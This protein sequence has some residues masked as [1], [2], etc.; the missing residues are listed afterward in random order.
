MLTLAIIL[1]LVFVGLT[2]YSMFFKDNLN[3]KVKKK[4]FIISIISYILSIIILLLLGY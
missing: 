2:L 1:L 4:Y 3:H